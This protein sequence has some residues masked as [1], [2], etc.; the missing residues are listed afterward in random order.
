VSDEDRAFKHG[1]PIVSGRFLAKTNASIF[2]TRV[3]VLPF[4]WSASPEMTIKDEKFPGCGSLLPRWKNGRLLKTTRSKFFPKASSFV[5]P[6][7][8]EWRESALVNL[9]ETS[10]RTVDRLPKENSSADHD[11]DPRSLSLGKLA[12][13][14]V[15]FGRS[16]LVRKVDVQRHSGADCFQKSGPDHTDN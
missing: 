15:S 13:G 12:R 8:D 11:P 5:L 2:L 9:G 4:R 10:W 16:C 3:P 1:S 14:M 7:P 6:L